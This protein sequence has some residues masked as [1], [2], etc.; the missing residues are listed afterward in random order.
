M[1]L[2]NL[3]A[4]LGKQKLVDGM[5]HSQKMHKHD[6]V[7]SLLQKQ[8][9]AELHNFIAKQSSTELGGYLDSLPLEDARNLWAKLPEARENDV[10]WEMSD[11][12]RI[13]VAGD[14]QPDF[15]ESKGRL[16]R[17]VCQGQRT[18]A[19][20]GDYVGPDAPEHHQGRC[21]HPSGLQLR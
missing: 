13:E 6:V 2:E 5:V 16:R 17:V 8:H 1:S 21:L 3:I 18:T 7:Q 12:R 11:Q 19:H 4:M 14:R 20:H 10:L 15:A 9:D